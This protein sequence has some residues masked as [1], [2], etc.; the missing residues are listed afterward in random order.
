MKAD[1]VTYLFIKQAILIA[2]CCKVLQG[3]FFFWLSHQRFLQGC[4]KACIF[5]IN[6]TADSICVMQMH[7]HRNR[8]SVESESTQHVCGFSLSSLIL[9]FLL[10]F[11]SPRTILCVCFVKVR[12]ALVTTLHTMWFDVMVT[13]WL[14]FLWVNICVC[15]SMYK[16]F[17]FGYC[18]QPHYSVESCRCLILL[19]LWMC[20][21]ITHILPY[22]HTS[23]S[24]WYSEI[25]E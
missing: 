22:N 19:L 20:G 3:P 17:L 13:I 23:Q 5:T 14:V 8:N 18:N 2:V 10:D 15:I 21:F 12:R 9:A 1:D 24:H 25:N 6:Q 4:G 11:I 16:Y 7:T